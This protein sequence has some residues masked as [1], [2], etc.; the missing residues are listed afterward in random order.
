MDLM[1]NRGANGYE[2]IGPYGAVFK[3]ENQKIEP[4]ITYTERDLLTQAFFVFD[5]I[6]STQSP[7][8]EIILLYNP[9]LSNTTYLPF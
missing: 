1:R 3:V 6:R 7:P 5:R 4:T 9:Y 8:A 2:I